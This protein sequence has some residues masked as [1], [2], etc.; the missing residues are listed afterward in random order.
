VSRGLDAPPDAA[1]ADVRLFL[2]NAGALALSTGTRALTFA[3]VVYVARRLGPAP[4]GVVAVGTSAAFALAAIA[5]LGLETLVVREV[6]IARERAPRVLGDAAALKLLAVPVAAAGWALLSVRQPEGAATFAL[7]LAF[8][9]LNSYLGLAWAALRGIERMELPAALAA[10]QTCLIAAGAAAA[11]ALAGTPVAV[12][13]AYALA[14]LA[15]LGA[16]AATLGWCGLRPALRVAP[17]ALPPLVAAT[18][19]F[20]LVYLGA[21]WYEQ[22]PTVLVGLLDGPGEAGLFSAVYVLMLALYLLPTLVGSVLLPLLT[23]THGRGADRSAAAAGVVLR[24]TALLGAAIALG[25]AAVAPGLV[26]LLYTSAYAGA[27]PLLRVLALGA[28]G[29]FLAL[30]AAT[31]LQAVGSRWACAGTIA[32]WTLAATAASV[33]VTARWGAA[34]VAVAAGVAWYV[35]AAALLTVLART[36]P[37]LRLGPALARPGAAA[38]AMAAVLVAGQALPPWMTLPA[39]VAAFA[40]VA[41]AARAVEPAEWRAVAGALGR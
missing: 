33:P 16:S 23:R 17:S 41:A 21:A 24:H 31:I 1:L 7:F 29:V 27:A 36:L 18:A 40:A 9:L 30:G 26:S 25:L 19:P 28:P 34:G 10:V 2:K 37:G 13:A 32:A 35:L 11:A 8:G 22:L 15:V 38:A 39:A 20:A 6:A 14:T 4:F 12:G 5:N 3:V